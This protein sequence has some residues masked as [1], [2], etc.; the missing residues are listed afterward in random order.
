[1]KHST[2][3]PANWLYL[4]KLGKTFGLKGGLYFYAAGEAEAAALFALQEA[5]RQLFIVGLGKRQLKEVQARA[6]GHILF[7]A[8]VQHIDYA[9]PLVNAGVYADPAHLPEDDDIFYVDALLELPVFRDGQTFGS[10]VEI[11]EAGQQDILVIQHEEQKYMI[12]LQADYVS[13]AE[14]GVHI[15]DAPAGLFELQN[16]LD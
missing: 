1:M 12:P 16:A 3:P 5:G 14:D 10:I 7:F 9:R 6:K 8:G 15:D 11:I 2:E 4:G 13:L